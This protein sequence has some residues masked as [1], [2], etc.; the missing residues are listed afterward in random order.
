MTTTSTQRV[1]APLSSD[2]VPSSASQWGC[3]CSPADATVTYC[4]SKTVDLDQIVADADIVVA[5]VGRPEL[6]KGQ[7]IKPGAV[8]IDAGYNPGNRGDVEY[9]RSGRAGPELKATT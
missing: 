6:I 9:A 4:H 5:V 8:I 1:C 3:C 2:A 7:W